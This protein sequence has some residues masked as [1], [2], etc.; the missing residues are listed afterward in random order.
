MRLLTLLLLTVFCSTGI[1]E[2]I[3]QQA[4]NDLL[5][6]EFSIYRGQA[7]IAQ[8]IYSEHIKISP[9]NAAL[10]ERATK[11]SLHTKDYQSMLE[12]AKLW[13]QASPNPRAELYLAQAYSHNQQAKNAFNTLLSLLEK[14][15][16][17]NFTQWVK[18]L[19]SE[20]AEILLFQKKLEQAVHKHPN[21][22]DLL[23]ANSLFFGLMQQKT[24]AI[25]YIEKAL[26]LDDSRQ[27]AEPALSLFLQLNEQNKALDLLQAQISKHPHQTQLQHSLLHIA[28]QSADENLLKQQLEFLLTVAPDNNR[29]L[30]SLASLQMQDGDFSSA[31][32]LLLQALSNDTDYGPAHFYLGL[33]YT[34]ERQYENAKAHLLSVTSPD[35]YWTAQAYLAHIHLEQN[36]PMQAWRIIERYFEQHTLEQSDQRWIMLKAQVLAEQNKY[37]QAVALYQQA[38]ELYPDSSELRY[39]RAMLAEKHDDLALCEQDLRDIIALHPD[40]AIA[41]NA[42][43]YILAD[44]TERFAEAQQLI[45]QALTLQPDDAATLDS[46]GWVLYKRGQNTKA[47]KFL[48][49]AFELMHDAEIVAH[50]AEVL[51]ETGQKKQAAA[52][53]RDAIKQS[54]NHP[55]LEKTVKRLE[56]DL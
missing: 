40:H 36:M 21:H 4:L 20:D 35:D 24:K 34:Q 52:I 32:K 53:L 46:M 44:R 42:L 48:K 12:A 54:P 41:I 17:T 16:K 10:A 15:E 6:A 43:G 51:L 49:Q 28:Q 19:S 14:G 50:Y 45:E 22:L 38:L 2:Q 30:I 1:A 3:S 25:T 29:Y 26:S 55:L 9:Y 11:L 18:T 33:L 23:I 56:I 47:L 13:Q 37:P 7:E 27:T 5:K 39:S 31:E 8:A